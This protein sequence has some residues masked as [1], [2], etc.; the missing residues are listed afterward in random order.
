MLLVQNFFL[1]S[2]LIR[3]RN[4]KKKETH[5]LEKDHFDGI[6]SDMANELLQ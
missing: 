4:A 1:P 3:K 5:C 6:L 2:I